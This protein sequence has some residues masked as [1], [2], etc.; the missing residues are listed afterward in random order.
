MRSTAQEA[1]SISRGASSEAPYPP[2][3]CV[4]VSPYRA[5]IENTLQRSHIRLVCSPKSYCSLTF[6]QFGTPQILLLLWFFQYLF[7][8][9]TRR[10]VLPGLNRHWLLC[11]IARVLDFRLYFFFASKRNEANRDPFRMRFACSLRSFRFLFFAIFAYFRIKSFFVFALFR[12]SNF[13]LNINCWIW[14]FSYTV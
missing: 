1:N 13:L 4:A 7:C 6:K 10:S 8:E 2:R 12:F 9:I 14:V 11:I 3:T 5:S